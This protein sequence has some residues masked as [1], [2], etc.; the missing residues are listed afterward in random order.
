MNRHQIVANSLLKLANRKQGVERRKAL[1][2]YRFYCRR[3]NLVQGTR[4]DV[5]KGWEGQTATRPVYQNRSKTDLIYAEVSGNRDSV[6]NYLQGKT[7]PK[8]K[9]ERIEVVNYSVSKN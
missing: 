2:A 1:Q 4:L 6:G 7:P 3:N 9:T 8:N 5:Q